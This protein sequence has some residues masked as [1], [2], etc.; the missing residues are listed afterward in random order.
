M[1]YKELLVPQRAG[2]GAEYATLNPNAVNLGGPSFVKHLINCTLENDLWETEPGTRQMITD[3][4]P[5]APVIGTVRQY[6]PYPAVS[7]MVA[8][9]RDGTIWVSQDDGRVYE[10]VVSGLTPGAL[11][12]PVEGGAEIAGNSKKLFL[13]GGGRPQVLSGDPSTALGLA[14]PTVPLTAVIQDV[15]GAIN[16]GQH[17]YTYVFGSL[18]GETAPAPLTSLVIANGNKAKALLTVPFGPPG[19]TYRRIYRT[20][21][22][23]PA[24]V[25]ITPSPLFLHTIPDNMTADYT[26]AFSDGQIGNDGTTPHRVAPI[27]NGTRTVR[28]ITRPPRDWSGGNQPT[29]GFI[30]EGRLACFGNNNNKHFLYVSSR[31]DHEDF[32]SSPITIPVFTG[33]ADAISAGFYWRSQGWVLKSPRGIY[34]I[35]SSEIDPVSW[36]VH[37]HSD[38]VGGVGPM[39]L[40]LIQGSDQSQFYDDVVFVAPDGSWHR[41]SKTAAYQLGDVNASSISEETYGQ[42]IRDEVDKARLPFCQVIYFDQI[43]ELW[44]GFT[45]I[46][47]QINNLRIKMNIKRLPAVGIRFHHSTFPECEAL[48]LHI[49]T[50]LTRTPVAAGSGGLIKV[51]YQKLYSDADVPYTSEFT[52]WDDNFQHLGEEYKISQKNYHFL[53]VEG[54]SVGDWALTIWVY[55]DGVLQPTVLSIP[56]KGKGS[57]FI[58]DQ[59]RLD[60]QALGAIKSLFVSRRLRGRG[61]RI[62][63]RGFLSSPNYFRIAQ[64]QTA[65]SI[66]GYSFGNK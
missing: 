2:Q 57:Q 8:C 4:L 36:Q 23:D 5:G 59:S 9:G 19:T 13:F 7:R 64:I 46:G 30:L 52:T 27:S 24:T 12:V 16:V 29:A 43:E 39:A 51:A 1:G 60:Q 32:L 21:A 61:H 41:M 6:F 14:D 45:R 62:S 37:E 3:P 25:T 31:V 17:D 58:L 40:A 53:I 47:S 66:G 34:R 22:Y 48:A 20:I 26:D 63:Y 35:D 11:M 42:F 44:G 33:K 10:Q 55:L 38:A 49:N 56:M 15:S 18:V 28:T 54:V 65:F 50:D